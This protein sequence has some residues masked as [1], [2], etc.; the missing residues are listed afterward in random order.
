MCIGF[1]NLAAAQAIVHG[2]CCVCI[3]QCGRG[4]ELFRKKDSVKDLERA[5]NRQI[6]C[7]VNQNIHE[8]HD[9]C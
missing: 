4:G 1:L 5:K 6:T 9:I 2:L 3:S 8:Y 7:D